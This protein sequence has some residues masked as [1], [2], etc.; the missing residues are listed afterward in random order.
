M[1]L[2]NRA[3]NP[4]G[5]APKDLFPTDICSGSGGANCGFNY[6]G[7]PVPL[8]VISVFT[9]KNYVS[10]T[11]ADYTAILA[12]IE[13]RFGVPPLAKRDAAQMD[14]TEFFDFENVPWF[15]PPSP[16][17]QATNG[18]CNYQQLQ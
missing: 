7:F 4:D 9:K 10:L 6:T 12:F 5:I 11:V 2:R 15:T 14:M 18:V 13:K 1:F 3:V 16:S 17:T 8:L